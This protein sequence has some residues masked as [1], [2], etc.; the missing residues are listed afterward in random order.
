MMYSDRGHHLSDKLWDETMEEFHF[1]GVH[2]VLN[3]AKP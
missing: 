1:A 2:K 3:M